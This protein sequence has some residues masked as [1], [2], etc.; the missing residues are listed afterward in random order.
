[1]LDR[2]HAECI[3]RGAGLEEKDIQEMFKEAE[4]I[5]GL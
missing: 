5:I 2:N 1:L 4:S 3:A